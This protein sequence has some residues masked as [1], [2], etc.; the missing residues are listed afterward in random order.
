MSST[1]VLKFTIALL[2]LSSLISCDGGRQ[3]TNNGT[4]ALVKLVSKSD[5]IDNVVGETVEVRNCVAPEIKTTDCSAGTSNGLSIDFGGSIGVENGFSGSIESSVS[6]SLGIGQQSGQSI[7]LDLPPT[8][9]IYTYEVNKKY[10]V[11]NGEVLARS[12]NAEEQVVN[13]VFYASCSITIVSQKQTSC[14]NTGKKITVFANKIW[15]DT[16][17]N[18]QQGQ[19]LNVTASGSINTWGGNPIGDTPNPNGQTQNES[20]PSTGNLPD[21]LIN[22][23]LYGTLI[24]KIG[25]NG[26][27]FRIGAENKIPVSTSGNLYLAVNDDEPYFDDNSGTYSVLITVK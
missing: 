2:I 14:P 24:G 15:Q 22:G 5:P 12:S 19:T 20:C 11:V 26:T 1:S 10:S 13:Y 21:C 4:W 3:T 8:G 6:S 9:F 7:T 17:I 16:G 25:K 18:V 27:P 23:E